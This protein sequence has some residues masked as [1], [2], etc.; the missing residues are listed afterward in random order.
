MQSREP[1]ILH[2]NAKIIAVL[3]FI[4][5]NESKEDDFFCDGITEDILTHLSK[6]AD[7]KVI[8]RTSMLKYKNTYSVLLYLKKWK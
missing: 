7:L 6:I 3:P 2:E 1:T 5:I 8:S 4:N